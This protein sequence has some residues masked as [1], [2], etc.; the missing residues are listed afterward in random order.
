VT[1]AEEQELLQKVREIYRY[2][3]IGGENII[4]MEKTKE[5][6]EKDVLSW[7]AKKLKKI[8]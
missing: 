1:P 6:I 8:K 7:R 2:L 3:N 5:K 4:S